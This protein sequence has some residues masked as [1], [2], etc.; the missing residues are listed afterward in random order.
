MKRSILFA[1]CTVIVPVSISQADCPVDEGL[2]IDRQPHNAGGPGADT[3]FIN[4]FNQQVWQLVADDIMVSEAATIRQ[5]CWWGFYNENDPPESEVMRVRFYSDDGG[6]PGDILFEQELVNPTRVATGEVILVGELPPEYLFESQIDP[7]DMA[8][9][10]LYWLEIV[11]LGDMDSHY[12]W[13]Y[14]LSEP[15]D[16]AFRNTFFPEWDNAGLVSSL[17]FQLS[18]VPEPTTV[19]L[20]MLGGSLLIRNRRARRTM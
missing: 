12:R 5:L 16:F 15:T 14:S 10:T 8:A 20:V 7:F 13:E 3:D 18:T 19:V 6:L 17:A 2:V 11:Q 1:A 4:M 9:N